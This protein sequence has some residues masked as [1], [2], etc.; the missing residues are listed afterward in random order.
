MKNIYCSFQYLQ[1]Y[2]I[3]NRTNNKELLFRSNENRRY[4]L[5]LIITNLSGFIKFYAYALLGNHFHF[6]VSVRHKEDILFHIQEKKNQ[7]QRLST[8][9]AIFLASDPNERD[10]HK[11]ISLQWSKAFNSYAQ[12]YNKSYKRKG[13]LF[14]KGFKR[15]L[16]KHET[17][18]QYL[19][20]YIHHNSRR[21]RIVND[22]LLDEWHSYH[23]LVDDESTFLERDFIL[24]WFGGKNEFTEFHKKRFL[25]SNFESFEFG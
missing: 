12:A 7:N 6:A 22:F 5:S 20:Y 9:E 15:A 16:I 2:H 25:E 19:I 23:S 4:F 13:N 17:R 21:H 14:N 8:I 3:F 10:I 1:T 11:L 24:D 18:F